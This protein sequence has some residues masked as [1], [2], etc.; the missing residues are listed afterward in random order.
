MPKVEVLWRL[1]EE[2]SLMDSSCS[3]FKAKV[4]NK[5]QCSPIVSL[6][7]EYELPVLQTKNA[8]VSSCGKDGRNVP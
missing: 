5:G 4:D 6:V 2:G 1:F 3:D 8:D 7:E